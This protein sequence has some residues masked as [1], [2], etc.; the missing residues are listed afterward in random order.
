MNAG[1]G[2]LTTGTDIGSLFI[3]GFWVY[4]LN[5]RCG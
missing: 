2:P 3:G 4:T 1:S 5:M